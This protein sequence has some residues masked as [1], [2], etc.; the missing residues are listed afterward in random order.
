MTL[1]DIAEARAK[2]VKR[3]GGVMPKVMYVPRD[4]MLE[5]YQM[6]DPGMTSVYGMDIARSVTQDLDFA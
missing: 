3:N 5:L 4:Q 1:S 6:L 2:W